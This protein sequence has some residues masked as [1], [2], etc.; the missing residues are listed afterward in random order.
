MTG[1][2]EGGVRL[3]DW[4]N[5]PFPK[6]V[7]VE[8]KY[9]HQNRDPDIQCGVKCISINC[10]WRAPYML[11]EFDKH[12]EYPRLKV[13]IAATRLTMRQDNC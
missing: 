1:R 7:R 3:P 2:G 9:F 6:I 5:N 13:Q 12:Q 11:H 4:P 8:K 10:N